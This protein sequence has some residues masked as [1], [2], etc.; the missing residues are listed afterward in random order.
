MY[1]PQSNTLKKLKSLTQSLK[2]Y[3]T[4]PNKI[5]GLTD[6]KNEE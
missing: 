5:R 4:I 6:M 1:S 3:P 2:K